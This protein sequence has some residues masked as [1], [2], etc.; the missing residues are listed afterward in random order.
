MFNSLSRPSVLVLFSLTVAGIMGGCS[1]ASDMDSEN[2]EEAVKAVLLAQQEAWNTGDIDAFMDGYLQSDDIRFVS[3]SGEI[4]G[5]AATLARYHR[6]YPDRASM[7][8]LTFDLKEVRVLSSDY[9]FIF[10]A[11][12][13]ERDGDRPTGLFSLLAKST[14]NGWK[15]I[16]DHTSA[17]EVHANTE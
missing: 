7:G 14:D 12:A 10:G 11:Y 4:R 15:L 9:A 16:H 17:D 2:A 13:L 3:S 8:R 5:W 6:A 1:V